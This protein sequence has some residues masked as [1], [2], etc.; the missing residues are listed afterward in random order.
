MYH[1]ICQI[2]RRM[3]KLNE[4]N[5]QRCI[6]LRELR[7]LEHAASPLSA[8]RGKDSYR[9]GEGCGRG[10]RKPGEEVR[11][12]NQK[13]KILGFFI[14]FSLCPELWAVT[15]NVCFPLELCF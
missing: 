9:E 14:S 1:S 11:R 6:R 12:E 15:C 5:H 10:R 8:R 4:R 3:L 7:I 13:Q 2:F